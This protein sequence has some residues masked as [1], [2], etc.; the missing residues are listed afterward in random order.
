MTEQS[1]EV[2]NRNTDDYQKEQK[3]TL[4]NEEQNLQMK[5]FWSLEKLNFSG[6]NDSIKVCSV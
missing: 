3:I 5:I 6:L 2:M 1:M 4:I